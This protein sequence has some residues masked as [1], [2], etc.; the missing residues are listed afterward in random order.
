MVVQELKEGIEFALKNAM[1]FSCREIHPHIPVAEKISGMPSK[2]LAVQTFF[3][4]R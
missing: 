4:K 3:P 1:G 2:P